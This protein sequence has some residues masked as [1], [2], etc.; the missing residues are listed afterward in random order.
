M[1]KDITKFVSKKSRELSIMEK[2]H[3][4]IKGKSESEIR[5][6]ELALLKPKPLPIYKGSK[7]GRSQFKKR[8]ITLTFPAESWIDKFADYFK[9]NKY[10]DNNS[11]DIEF[12]ME[13]F[14]LFDKGRL[15]WD[16]DTKKLIVKTIRKEIVL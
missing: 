5:D 9:V 4:L 3:K 13:I 10:L 1:S 15:R 2:F 12:L 6:I 8:S 7:V 11:Y 14:R 16:K